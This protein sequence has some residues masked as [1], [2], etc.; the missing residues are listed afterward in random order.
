MENASTSAFA[1]TRAD[2]RTSSPER[3]AILSA[4]HASTYRPARASRDRP[5]PPRGRRFFQTGRRPAPHRWRLQRSI[6]PDLAI[7]RLPGGILHRYHAE[8]D[9]VVLEV[10]ARRLEI[11]R[12]VRGLSP[13]SA[14][15]T[16]RAP[17]MG[18][19][20]GGSPYVVE[21]PR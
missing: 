8:R 19:I 11:E 10:E 15:Q 2:A 17:G 4:A 12:C 5:R 16:P 21:S 20:G 14:S 6:R 1:T 7:G 9:D 18:I 3:R 13:R